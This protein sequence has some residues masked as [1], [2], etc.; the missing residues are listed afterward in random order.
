M[1]EGYVGYQRDLARELFSTAVNNETATPGRGTRTQQLDG[2]VARRPSGLVARK[3]ARD[4]NGVA[5]DASEKL[6]AAAT[7]SGAS[8]PEALQRKFEASLGADLS[9]VRVHTNA[10]S[11]RAADAVGAKAYTTGQDIHFGAGHYDPSSQGGEHLLAHEVAHTVQQ[12]GGT[13]STQYKLEVSAPGDAFELDADRAADAMVAG[14]A[15]TISSYTPTVARVPDEYTA[16]ADDAGANVKTNLS[17]QN[18]PVF[19]LTTV[20]DRN[21][22]EGAISQIDACTADLQKAMASGQASP[23][24]IGVNEQAKAALENYIGTL[25]GE[26]I[27]VS[28]FQLMY[29]RVS[30]DYARLDAMAQHAGCGITDGVAS[31]HPDDSVNPNRATAQAGV[32]TANNNIDTIAGQNGAADSMAAAAQNDKNPEVG[33]LQLQVRGEKAKL[34][35]CSTSVTFAAN[36]ATNDVNAINGANNRVISA[37]AQI[38]SEKLRAEVAAAQQRIANNAQ[39]LNAISALVG[40]ALAAATPGAGEAAIALTIGGAIVSALGPLETG[41]PPLSLSA[42]E[43]NAGK[44]AD[45]DHERALIANYTGA[46]QDFAKAVNALQNDAL[47]L[48][49]ALTNLDGQKDTYKASLMALGKQLDDDQAKQKGATGRKPGELG[50]YEAISV[51]LSEADAFLAD[52]ASAVKFGEEQLNADSA[53]KAAQMTAAARSSKDPNLVDTENMTVRFA[54]PLYD[55]DGTTQ[56]GW[57]VHTTHLS[58]K[59]IGDGNEHTDAE[60]DEMTTQAACAAIERFIQAISGYRA[61]LA[62]AMGGGINPPA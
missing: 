15:A 55:V 62:R 45:V 22:A 60:H 34:D 37:L 58:I 29:K 12:R 7:G 57:A 51:F 35:A 5:G 52:A 28:S 47:L 33:R 4:D 21:A 30:V 8:L 1:K 14:H 48:S 61:Q 10:E 39:A 3:A 11:A 13:P 43:V 32:A 42:D 38:T 23:E 59:N 50:P 9:G 18:D 2:P 20:N 31:Q 56:T 49:A 41:W 26:T 53:G 36:T 17:A 54:V 27:S 25:A 16:T 44:Q 6:D 40:G 24:D 46:T 19:A